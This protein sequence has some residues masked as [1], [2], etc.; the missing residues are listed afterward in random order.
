MNSL[1]GLQAYVTATDAGVTYY[2]RDGNPIWES[3]PLADISDH[4][5]RTSEPLA[6]EAG[7]MANPHGAPREGK[8]LTFTV[9]GPDAVLALGAIQGVLSGPVPKSML[10]ILTSSFAAT[11]EYFRSKDSHRAQSHYRPPGY[12]PPIRPRPEPTIP[13]PN[14]RPEP[15]FGP[16]SIESEVRKRLKG[17]GLLEA[18]ARGQVHN[19]QKRGA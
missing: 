14:P 13:K 5:A 17:W 11:R 16:P 18:Y 7:W 12:Q 15:S 8:R 10:A 2:P 1:K 9:E 6:A 19:R 4:H 3:F